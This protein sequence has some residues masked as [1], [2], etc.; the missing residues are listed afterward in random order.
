VRAASKLVGGLHLGG[1][2]YSCG[3]IVRFRPQVTLRSQTVPR[4]QGAPDRSVSIGSARG[5]LLRAEG[6]L[7][8]RR[9]RRPSVSDSED[10][11]GDVQDA[12]LPSPGLGRVNGRTTTAAVSMSPASVPDS[13]LLVPAD[14]LQESKRPHLP[15]SPHRD[16][17]TPS[18][19]S[20]HPTR[21]SSRHARRSCTTTSSW[22][23]CP[24]PSSS[25]R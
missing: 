19:T 6:P 11:G 9:R 14:T 17:E 5:L 21:R 1:E 7:Q 18:A 22:A 24:V 2:H 13:Q 16:G 10:E 12:P 4:G 8:F 23:F 3:S 20:C 15:L 25:T